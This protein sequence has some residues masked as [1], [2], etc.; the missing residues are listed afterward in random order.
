MVE[1]VLTAHPEIE[2]TPTMIS[3][4]LEG[5]SAGAIHNVLEKMVAA[6]TVRRMCDKPKRYQHAASL[7][8]K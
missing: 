6:G 7:A 3:H 8:P 1:A 2:Y 4:M 5:R